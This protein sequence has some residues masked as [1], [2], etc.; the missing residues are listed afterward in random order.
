VVSSKW[1]HMGIGKLK[2][3]IWVHFYWMFHLREHVRCIA[4]VIFW[5]I[6]QTWDTHC[7]CWATVI[8]RCN[9]IKAG[10]VR[11]LQGLQQQKN[12]LTCNK[13][14]WGHMVRTN[15]LQLCTANW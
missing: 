7:S 9:R 8:L 13:S 14:W 4:M 12:P 1:R 10:L 2:N 6:Y 3:L 15:Y 5:N 11:K